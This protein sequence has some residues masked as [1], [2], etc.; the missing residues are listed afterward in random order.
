MS[1]RVRASGWKRPGG[2]SPYSPRSITMSLASW[3]SPFILHRR[4]QR[5]RA[6]RLGVELLEDRTLLSGSS[7]AM[8]LP[9]SPTD[10]VTGQLGT[11]GAA[12]FYQITL[13]DPGRLSSLTQPAAGT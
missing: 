6:C 8:P 10:T 2:E 13:T 11:A 9:I 4:P 3:P 7:L 5:R 1:S 12:D